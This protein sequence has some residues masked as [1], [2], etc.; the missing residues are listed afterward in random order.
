MKVK[1]LILLFIC[2]FCLLGCNKKEI[3]PDFTIKLFYLDT[4]GHCEA[5]K[6]QAVPALQKKFKD[7]IHIEYYN[8]DEDESKELYHNLCDEL[9]FYDQEDLDDVPFIVMDDHFAL[10]GYSTGEEKE[11]MKD[12]ERALKNEPLGEKLAAYRWEF[13][14]WKK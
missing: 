9:Y 14:L 1:K 6:Q 8:M 10:L 2:A 13:N 5:F 4:C 12:I 11:L 7:A 3:Y